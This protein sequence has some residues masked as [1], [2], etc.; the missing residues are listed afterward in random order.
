MWVREEYTFKYKSR[1]K[2]FAFAYPQHLKRKDH[3]HKSSEKNVD[4]VYNVIKCILIFLKT[5]KKH[6]Q[7]C[8]MI[9]LWMCI[10]S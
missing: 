6:T 2:G 9:N 4:Y 8:V 10:M 3:V 7:R 1:S 5:G